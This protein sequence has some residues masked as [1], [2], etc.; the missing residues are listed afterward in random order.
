MA[1]V[2]LLNALPQCFPWPSSS[3]FLLLI[4]SDK[5]EHMSSC[6]KGTHMSGSQQTSLEKIP[7]AGRDWGQEEKGTTE[8]EM[9]GWHHQLDGHEFE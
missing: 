7:D 2:L 4:W 9:A 3:C 1:P 5:T 6:G 8:D